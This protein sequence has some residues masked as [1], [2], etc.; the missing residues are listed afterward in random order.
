[1]MSSLCSQRNETIKWA[2]AYL[3]SKTKG[4]GGGRRKS[5]EEGGVHWNGGLCP[6]SKPL[7]PQLPPHPHPPQTHTSLHLP[8]VPTQARPRS[9]WCEPLSLKDKVSLVTLVILCFRQS[10]S[11]HPGCLLLLLE[12]TFSRAKAQGTFW[13][14]S[15]PRSRRCVPPSHHRSRAHSARSWMLCFNSLFWHRLSIWLVGLHR[16][17]YCIKAGILTLRRKKIY[18]FG[19][20]KTQSLLPQ[21]WTAHPTKDRGQLFIFLL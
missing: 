16:V 6:S 8:P 4:G 19:L 1:M 11:E 14:Q 15:I 20:K 5:W 18:I 3:E 2:S 12:V 17:W 13:G 7:S 10:C 9:S 21:E